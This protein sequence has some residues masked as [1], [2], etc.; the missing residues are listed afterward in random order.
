MEMY[1]KMYGTRMRDGIVWELRMATA[2]LKN[3]LHGSERVGL[4]TGWR[5]SIKELKTF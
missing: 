4:F 3:S 1:K 5:Q 2:V